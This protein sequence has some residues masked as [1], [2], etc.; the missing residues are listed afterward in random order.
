M[1]LKRFLEK[2]RYYDLIEYQGQKWAIATYWPYDEFVENEKDL[3]MW[4]QLVSDNYDCMDLKVKLLDEIPFSP[5][6]KE[7]FML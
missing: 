2:Y 6:D 4:L 7:H 1:T 3:I 5:C